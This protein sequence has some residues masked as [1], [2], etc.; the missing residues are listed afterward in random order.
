MSVFHGCFA[1]GRLARPGWRFR[2]DGCVRPPLA[3]PDRQGQAWACPRFAV[4][5]RSGLRRPGRLA[6]PSPQAMRSGLAAGGAAPLRFRP[7]QRT[8]TGRRRPRRVGA[9]R[10]G[11][12]VTAC[13]TASLICACRERRSD[14]GRLERVVGPDHPDTLNSW[15]N[16][17]LAYQEAGRAAEAIALL[18]RTLADFEPVLARTT[19]TSCNPGTTS[20]PPGWHWPDAATKP[21]ESPEQTRPAGGVIRG[22]RCRFCRGGPSAGAGSHYRPTRGHAELPSVRFLL[23]RHVS[24]YGEPY[25]P[26][27]GIS[28]A[29]K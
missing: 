7:G 28:F 2:R 13:A 15:H 18:E 5:G 12:M 26:T 21:A 11:G 25:R 20:P 24:T 8:A 1:H 6:G 14:P 23:P 27:A 10:R 22:S 3:G 29:W 17:A 9:V 19:P 16:L 4:G